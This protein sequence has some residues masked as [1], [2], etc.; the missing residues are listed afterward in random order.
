MQDMEQTINFAPSFGTRFS[1]SIDTEEEFHWAGELSRE[2]HATS[3]I[4]ALRDGQ[5]FF[6]AAG[7]VPLYYVDVPIAEQGEAVAII[8]GA[9][10]DGT[11][12]V[13]AHLH[14]WVTPPFVEDVNRVNSYAGNLPEDVERA[15]V[16]YIR[17]LIDRR[18]GTRPIAYRAGRYGIGPNSYRILAEEGFRCDSSVRS[19]FDYRRDGGPDFSHG[20]HH[21]YVVGGTSG[22]IELPLTTVFAGQAGR[23]GRSLYRHFERIPRLRGFLARTGLVERVALTPEGIPADR[24]CAAIDIALDIGIR[25]LSI[26]FHSPSLAPGNTPYVRDAA[27]LAEFYRWFDIVLDHGARRGITPASLAQIL[28]AIVKP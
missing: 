5:R 13:G 19:L 10:A 23:V 1:V 6:A 7:V 28:G 9:V 8:G 2:G 22:I 26:S 3:A 17:D 21:P 27:E 4:P 11:A 15:K 18:F 12:E 20:A 24:A 25:L 14:P 16:C